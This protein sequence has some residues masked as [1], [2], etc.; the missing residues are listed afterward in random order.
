MRGVLFRCILE[1]MNQKK[2]FITKTNGKC[3]EFDINKVAY[4]LKKVGATEESIR[5]VLVHLQDEIK[6]GMTSTVTLI[7]SNSQY[8]SSP[9]QDS[10]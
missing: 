6:E 10:G 7:N 3:E 4:S 9:L 2:I 1:G 8:L 5:G